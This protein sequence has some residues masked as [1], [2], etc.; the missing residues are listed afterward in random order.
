M[1]NSKKASK[2]KY[3]VPEHLNL[4]ISSLEFEKPLVF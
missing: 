3:K 4:E 2:I 1:T